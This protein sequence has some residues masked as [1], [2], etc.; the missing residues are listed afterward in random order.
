MADS[1]DCISD[2]K[3]TNYKCTSKLLW[4]LVAV[5]FVKASPSFEASTLS[6]PDSNKL[7][8]NEIN[9]KENNNSC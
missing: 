9:I 3:F 4:F 2:W 8:L 7:R 6:K 1:Q 5:L